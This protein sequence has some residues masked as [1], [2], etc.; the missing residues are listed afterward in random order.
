MDILIEQINKA[1]EALSNHGVIAFPTETVFGL[2]VLFNDFEAYTKLNII[3]HRPED[4]PYTMMVKNKESISL[5][6][7][8]DEKIQRVINRFVPGSLTLLLKSKNN[9]PPYVTH[10][11][12]IIGIRVPTN[13]EAELLLKTID[14]PL[15]VPSANRSGEKPG[16]N[17]NEVKDIFKDELDYIIKGCSTSNLPS[18][19]VDFTKDTPILIRQG[20]ISFEDIL[21]IYYEK[22]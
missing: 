9:V 16:Y 21:S 13:K 5:Y 1:C 17:D 20:E 19:I 18:T 3:K 2:G 15:L 6:A 10:N 8:V 14:M 12:G 22:Q 7:F 11:S 4:K